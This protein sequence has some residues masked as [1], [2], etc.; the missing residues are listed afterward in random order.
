MLVIAMVRPRAGVS[1]GPQATR[2]KPT[3]ELPPLGLV[4]GV[5]ESASHTPLLSALLRE[6][7]REGRPRVDDLF[8][9]FRIMT[10]AVE[11]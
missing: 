11:S 4:C 3:A 2:A 6:M 7:G 8:V 1:A 9:I 10:T 5:R